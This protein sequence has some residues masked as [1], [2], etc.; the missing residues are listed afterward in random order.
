MKK[1][2]RRKPPRYTLARSHI[3]T[4][5]NRSVQ[6]GPISQSAVGVP[7]APGSLSPV[8]ILPYLRYLLRPV[9]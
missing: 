4:V 5:G 8:S 2:L 9:L 3:P 1:E 6:A 7:M